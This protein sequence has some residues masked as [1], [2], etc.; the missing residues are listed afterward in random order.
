[1]NSVI[2]GIIAK[3]LV[4]VMFLYSWFL[5][6]R[7]HHDTGGGF[8]GGLVSGSAL[9]IYALAFNADAATKLLP[10]R[11]ER[12]IASGLLVSLASTLVAFTQMKPVM[13]SV[14][15][16]H[17]AIGDLGTPAFFDIGVYLVVLG[18][19][20]KILLPLLEETSS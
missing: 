2:F 6:M 18:V 9:V 15:F 5:T 4:P 20:A 12:I 7:G 8:V 10:I 19:V 16:T 11:A 3:T 1:M 13:T 17:R 14:W